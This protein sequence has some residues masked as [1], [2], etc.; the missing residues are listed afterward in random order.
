MSFIRE[1]DIDPFMENVIIAARLSTS[2]SGRSYVYENGRLREVTII[3][4][5]YN[6]RPRKA[7]THKLQSY[8]NW[9]QGDIHIE[10]PKHETCLI[11][12]E[13]I[14]KSSFY[15]TCKKCSQ[16][17]STEAM[18]QWWKTCCESGKHPT[19]PS[20]RSKWLDHSVYIYE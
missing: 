11:L 10:T 6:P 7:V 12:Q 1:R 15:H 9:F 17:L 3:D 19:C 20:C 8:E 16:C 4:D 5:E 13:P 14:E 18:S 2:L